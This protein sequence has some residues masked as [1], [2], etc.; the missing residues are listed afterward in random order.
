MLW[1]CECCIVTPTTKK[2]LTVKI[3]SCGLVSCALQCPV[4]RLEGLGRAGLGP[5]MVVSRLTH[6]LTTN[7]S[8]P[9]PQPATLRMLTS[10]LCIACI[11]GDFITST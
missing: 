11:L 1:Q 2:F 3:T 4:S 7:Q 10:K 6:S 5:T 8:S 9:D